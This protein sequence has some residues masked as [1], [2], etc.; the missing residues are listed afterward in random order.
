MQD[1]IQ[2]II[3]RMI[4]NKNC[5]GL[6][7]SI[8]KGDD[9]NTYSAGNFKNDDY[10]FI[11]STTKLFIT[12]IILELEENNKLNIDDNISKY[13]DSSILQKLHIFKKKDYSDLI[14]IKDLLSHTSG[15]P[16]YFE[17]KN[18]GEKSILENLQNNIDSSWTF[19]DTI[20]IAKK[21]KPKFAPNPKKASYSDTNFQLLGKIIENVLECTIEEAINSKIIQKLN[22]ATS[23]LYS[24]V[25]DQRPHKLCFKEI[26]LD[27]PQS[28]TSFKADGGMVS[29]SS[30]MIVFLEAFFQGKLFSEKTLK[31]LYI[32]NRI[33]FPLEYGIGVMRFSMPRILSP[34]FKSL[35]LIGHSGLSGSFAF[36]NPNNN[37]YLA[38]TVNQ[39][40]NP[41][42]SF[43]LMMKVLN[44]LV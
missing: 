29:T 35:E 10:Y 2:A 30:D 28:M 1:K 34:S 36:Y 4:D 44:E 15:L 31:N 9:L 8:K 20:N 14:T 41:G 18:K 26:T 32:W 13:L 27:I 33:M 42:Q 43:R 6:V 39:I 24:D 12:A 7:M 16:D 21:M 5:F 22:L 40:S 3:D 38:G 19:E 11:A 25:L 37:I 23:Y 17:G